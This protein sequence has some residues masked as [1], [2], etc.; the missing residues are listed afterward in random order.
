[1]MATEKFETCWRLLLAN[2][3]GYT[4]DDGG[5]TRYGITARVAYQYGY[6]GAMQELPERTAETIACQEYWM[7]YQCDLFPTPIAF[8]ILDTVYNGGHPIAW[9]QEIIGGHQTGQ[10]LADVLSFMNPWEV[11]ARF[12]AKRLQYL[13][14]LKQQMYAD[15]RMNRIATNLQQ[16][17]LT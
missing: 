3:G 10:D 6:R 16:G 15:G 12:N 2:E 7:P 8:Q 5:A 11:V 4:V 13:A 1:M 17:S 9:L 14:S